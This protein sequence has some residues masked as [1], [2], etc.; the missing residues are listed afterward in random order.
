[1]RFRTIGFALVVVVLLVISY[2]AVVG[3]ATPIPD[4]DDNVPLPDDDGDGDGDG[5]PNYQYYTTFKIGVHIV[6]QDVLG[7]ELENYIGKVDSVTPT[8][9]RFVSMEEGRV[10]ESEKLLRGGG[11][12]LYGEYWVHIQVTGPSGYEAFWTSGLF[13]LTGH[14]ATAPQYGTIDTG[15][16]LMKDPGAY[17]ATV[18]LKCRN[19]ID[20]LSY[21][22]NKLV[23]PFEVGTHIWAVIG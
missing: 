14:M 20:N 8:I 7:Y 19:N 1:M 15:R 17:Q 3:F 11:G 22:L 23:E 16:F 4:A 12:L 9:E 18:T 13:P 21:D 6:S 2:W 5:I 10:F